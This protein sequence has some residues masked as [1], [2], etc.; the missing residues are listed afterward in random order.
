MRHFESRI[1]AMFTW[2]ENGV[3]SKSKAELAREVFGIAG[4]GKKTNGVG[5]DRGATSPRPTLSFFAAASA[6]FA[7]GALMAKDE[8]DLAPPSTADGEVVARNSPAEL[9]A[10]SDQA[11]SVF[12]KTSSYDV[13]SVVAMLLQ[14]LYL[15]HDGQMRV[16]QAVFPLMGKLVNVSRMMGLAIDP[17]EF[18]GTYSLFDAEMRRR[19]WWDVLYYDALVS[20]CMGQQALITDNC[21]TTRLPAEVD[22]TKFTPSSTTPPLPVPDEVDGSLSFFVLRC[23]LAQLIKS[24]QKQIMRD[25]LAEESQDISVDT[26]AAGENEVN[27]WLD[28]LPPAYKLST[29]LDLT[30][31][32][33]ANPSLSPN[34][35]GQR[36]VVAIVTNRLILKLYLP[37]LK[38]GSGSAP[39]KPSHQTVLGTINAAH[40]IIYASRLMHSIWRESRPATFDFY[41]F[42]RT[43]FD[44]AIVCAHTVI[45]QP[46]GVL[47]PEAMKCVTSALEVMRAMTAA[48]S[49]PDTGEAIKIVEMMKEKAEQARSLGSSE[50]SAA[51][52]KRKREGDNLITTLTAGFQ[53]PFVGPS[54]SSARPEQPRPPISMSKIAASGLKKDESRSSKTPKDKGKEKDKLPRYPP[55]GIRP[56]SY[57]A[58]WWKDVG[59]SNDRG[60]TS[61]VL[62]QSHFP[63]IRSPHALVNFNPNYRSSRFFRLYFSNQPPQ[64]SQQ[65][66][67]SQEPM[68][69]EYVDYSAAI[70]PKAHRRFTINERAKV[71]PS[72]GYEQSGLSQVQNLPMPPYSI[73]TSMAGGISSSI[74]GTPRE[75][76]YMVPTEKSGPSYDHQVGKSEL[77]RQMNHQYQPTAAAHGLPMT[78]TQMSVQGWPQSEMRANTWQSDYKYYTT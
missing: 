26:A 41:D 40:S 67:M 47:A 3:D 7:L 27:N 19:V 37:F 4:S 54:V 29:D 38:E 18:P 59:S 9:F 72:S 23:R 53:L 50:S 52:S 48:K 5:K 31:P 34:L 76:S 30:Q 63:F 32:F 66:I 39:S 12:E 60:R 49:R 24:M 10:L 2:N 62:S 44:A 71:L 42:G 36:C 73:D 25:P 28:E 17:D 45:Q 1:D 65:H 51:G 77:E 74:P 16:A 6:A 68:Q 20:E 35:L 64:Q 70:P 78:A 46:T 58:G 69:Q 57:D 56:K 43:L 14:V 75:Q 13:D 55:V 61:Y 22:E 8:G 33:A 15:L 11:L 21:F